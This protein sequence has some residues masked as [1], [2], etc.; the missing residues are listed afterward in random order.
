[1]KPDDIDAYVA[2]GGWSPRE[3]VG[4]ITFG[5]GTPLEIPS[6][7]MICG[8]P[9]KWVHLGGPMFEQRCVILEEGT[10]LCTVTTRCEGCF[11]VEERP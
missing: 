6:T 8:A 7:C 5:D 9:A 3:R 2:L 4:T 11:S 1:M 10:V